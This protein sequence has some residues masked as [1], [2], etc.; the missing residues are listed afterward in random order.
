MCCPLPIGTKI[1]LARRRPRYTSY[2]NDWSRGE[3]RLLWSWAS[4]LS[5]IGT[6]LLKPKTFCDISKLLPFYFIL[7]HSDTVLTNTTYVSHIISVFSFHVSLGL[8]LVPPQVFRLNFVYRLICTSFVLQ[9]A[10]II[11]HFEECKLKYNSYSKCSDSKSASYFRK[12]CIKAFGY[13]VPVI[14]WFYTLF[15]N[16]N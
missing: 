11:M 14:H 12:K 4:Q 5:R 16:N 13:S 2:L 6:F 8:Q 3:R 9:F 7:S 15:E 1:D 10:T